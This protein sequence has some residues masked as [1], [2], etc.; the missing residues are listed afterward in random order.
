MIPATLAAT[1]VATAMATIAAIALGGRAILDGRIGDAALC[2]AFAL[3][4]LALWGA[5][6]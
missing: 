6:L 3:A 5:A 2:L 4:G 1:V